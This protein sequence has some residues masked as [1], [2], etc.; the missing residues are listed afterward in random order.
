MKTFKVFSSDD[1]K[2]I[3]FNTTN[4]GIFSFLNPYSCL[5]L[6]NK[7]F[8]DIIFGVDSYYLA[9]LFLKIH[10][11]SFDNSSFAPYFFKHCI[12]NTKKVLFIGATIYENDLFISNLKINYKDFNA[13]G[14]N[15]YMHSQFYINHLFDNNYDFVVIGMGA[16]LQENLAFI[17]FEH[18]PSIK[19]ITCG[20]YIRQASNGLDYFP[21]IFT[22]LR[23]KF[24]YRFYKEPHVLKRT[25]YSYFKFYIKYFYGKYNFIRIQ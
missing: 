24:L 5:K 3:F 12:I 16:P 23:V 14:I 10:N 19:F 13:Y 20:G 17:L 22:K 7:N 21:Q 25:F 9:K 11:L 2:A 15:G 18:F 8:D 4:G 6:N 1:F